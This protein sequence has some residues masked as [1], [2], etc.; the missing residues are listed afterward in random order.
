[1]LGP[2]LHEDVSGEQAVLSAAGACKNMA[3]LSFDQRIG[4]DGVGAGMSDLPITIDVDKFRGLIVLERQ[5]DEFVRAYRHDF[6]SIIPASAAVLVEGALTIDDVK[7]MIGQVRVVCDRSATSVFVI[8]KWT[9][10]GGEK[11]LEATPGDDVG[12]LE[13]ADT[14]ARK[15]RRDPDYAGD[16]AGDAWERLK[17]LRWKQRELFEGTPKM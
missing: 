8:N 16:F 9:P 6:K 17:D 10:P 2:F 7:P 4:Q 5:D 3:A 13:F 1:M 11:I 12:L 14:L 15:T